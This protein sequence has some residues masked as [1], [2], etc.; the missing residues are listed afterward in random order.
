MRTLALLAALLLLALQAQAGLLRE[1]VDQ[2]PAQDLP[3]AEDQEQPGA[4]G[5]DM[6]ISF[7]GDDRLA[8]DASGLQRVSVCY[9]RFP[10]CLS[11]EYYYGRC[12]FNGIIYNLCCR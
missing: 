3:E 12:F 1:T 10:T 6:A 2:A 8:R 9:C 5:Q 4:T 7:G 11:S